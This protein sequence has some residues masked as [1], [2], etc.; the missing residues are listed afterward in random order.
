VQ[1]LFENIKSLSPFCFSYKCYPG[2]PSFPK[3]E[4]GDLKKIRKNEGKVALAASFHTTFSKIWL[5]Y[6]S[7][8]IWRFSTILFVFEEFFGITYTDGSRLEDSTGYAIVYGNQVVRERLDDYCSVFTA[9]AR[10][11]LRAC[12]LLGNSNFSSICQCQWYHL[13]L[14]KHKPGEANKP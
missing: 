10:A 12:R 11:V 14:F 13:K 7:I 3:I 8:E 5:N 4:N 9:E 2:L 6:I 1:L